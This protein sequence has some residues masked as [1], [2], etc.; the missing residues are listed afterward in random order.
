M[1]GAENDPFF[2][3]HSFESMENLITFVETEPHAKLEIVYRLHRIGKKLTRID[4]SDF[5]PK[6]LLGEWKYQV[7]MKRKMLGWVG[8]ALVKFK[9]YVEDLDQSSQ[10]HTA[11]IILGGS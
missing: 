1:G 6:G 10:A 9:E 8:G 3:S 4:R 2:Y 11:Q 7:F 5:I